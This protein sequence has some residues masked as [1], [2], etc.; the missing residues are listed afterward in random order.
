MAKVTPEERE[1][2]V[3]GIRQAI[4]NL[5]ITASETHDILLAAQDVVDASRLP[6][7]RKP[8]RTEGNDFLWG[9]GGSDTLTGAVD[10]AG[11]EDIDILLGGAGADTFVLGDEAQAFYDDGIAFT[12]GTA[13]V[14][15]IVDFNPEADT[16]QLHGDASNYVLGAI[17]DVLTEAFAALDGTA[18]YK[19]EG[20]AGEL[21]GIF[22]GT[23][24]TSFD[25]G[26]AFV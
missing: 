21:V 13:D 15:L 24:V 14:A 20:K 26:F 6:Q 23:E 5:G 10:D 25:K 16:V 19:Q 18:L 17:P 2:I 11:R 1:Q 3:T 9:K 4:D 12:Q 22:Y 7:T 8:H